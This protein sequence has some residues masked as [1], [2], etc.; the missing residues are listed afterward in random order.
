[1]RVFANLLWQRAFAAIEEQTP[2][3][4]PHTCTHTIQTLASGLMCVCAA[5]MAP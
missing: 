2:A 5:D 4:T 3:S 1:M